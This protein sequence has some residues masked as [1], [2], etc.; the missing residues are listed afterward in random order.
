MNSSVLL[1]YYF[2]TYAFYMSKLLANDLCVRFWRVQEESD[3]ETT[4]HHVDFTT[5]G[6]DQF[7]LEESIWNKTGLSVWDDTSQGKNWKKT[8]SLLL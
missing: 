2:S 7:Y 8:L 4:K 6:G 5:V 3:C 1:Q